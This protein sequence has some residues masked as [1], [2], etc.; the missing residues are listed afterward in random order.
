MSE[1]ISNGLTLTVPTRGDT[2]YHDTMRNGVFAPVSDHDHTG[3]G[4]GVQIAP[5]AIAPMAACSVLANATNA[6][7]TPTVVSAA[8]D[9]LILRRSGTTLGFGNISPLAITGSAT[10]DTPNVLLL[11]AT[12]QGSRL[13][14]SASALTTATPLTIASISLLAGD[15]D[16]KGAVGFNPGATTSITLLHAAIS[17]VNNTLPATS[18]LAVPSATGEFRAQSSAAAYVPGANPITIQIPAYRI[19]LASTTTI[20]LV[21]Q[22]TFTVST[23]A[24]FGYLEARRAR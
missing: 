13:L 14:A 11:G 18:T 20:Y 22:A 21:A 15:W 12:L 19:S 17:T 10:N 16:I 4:N 1:V 6:S 3:S 23:L 9:M 7:A 2:N 24:G 8:S 5:A